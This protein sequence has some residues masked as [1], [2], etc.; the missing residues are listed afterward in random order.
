MTIP[1]G[2]RVSRRRLLTAAAGGAVLLADPGLLTR[3]A[4]ARALPFTRELPIPEVLGGRH[5]RLPMVEAEV[6]ILPGAPTRM[7]TYGGQ[8]PGPTI[9][10]PAGHRT[11]ARFDHRLPGAAGELTVHLHGGHN[12][13]KDDGQPGGL[14]ARHPRSLYCDVPAALPA[15]LSNNDVL[16][17]PGDSRTYRYDLTEDGHAQR[18]AM[19]WY[20]DHRLDHTGRNVWR[21]LAG[22][23]IT[24]DAYEDALRLPHGDRE[25][26]LLIADR[27]F[28]KLN[29]LTDP[30]AVPGRAPFDQVTGSVVLVNGAPLPFHRVEARRYRLRVLNASNFRAFA[31]TLGAGVP[32]V[33][34]GTESGLLPRPVP[35]SRVVVGPGERVDLIVDFRRAAH[36]TVELRSA[37]RPGAPNSLGSKTWVGP[38]MRFDVGGRGGPDRTRMPEGRP[39]PGWVEA[40]PRDVAHE[41]KISVGGGFLPAWNINGR[42]Y[43][44]AFV[45][46][47]ARLGS[48]ERWRL[49][50]ATK[51]AHL[52]HLHHTDWLLLSRNGRRPPA[53]ERGL[54]ETFFLD[55][56]ERVEIAGRF[57]DYE[58]RY[59]VHCHM[60]EHEDHGLMSQFATYR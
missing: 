21:G 35:R 45:E 5:I 43:N 17:R 3:S 39:L 22:M 24:D 59:V 19:R 56:G 25:I 31:L 49:V 2:P 15:R 20:H 36:R 14:T 48:V 41:W 23:W 47:R 53:Y 1:G 11:M 27:S 42:A 9:R 29:Q 12:R 8:F 40:I 44:P 10:R 60:L 32:I 38:L 46:H 55:P 26:P 51:V 37:P 58:G 16:I 33:Q 30:F 50:N 28:N 54:K 34:I 7:W 13:A 52:V 4:R 18:A 6:P 57:S